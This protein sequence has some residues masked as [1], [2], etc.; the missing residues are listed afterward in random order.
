M[1]DNK[2]T[3][4]TDR[5]VLDHTRG[6][7]H[8]AAEA[9]AK[10]QLAEIHAFAKSRASEFATTHPVEIVYKH[11]VDPSPDPATEASFDAVLVDLATGAMETM[12]PYDEIDP[13]WRA[14]R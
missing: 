8:D 12:P 13:D 2:W 9:Q 7:D 14:K 5:I 6:L 1:A 4:P 3:I 11:P 10:A